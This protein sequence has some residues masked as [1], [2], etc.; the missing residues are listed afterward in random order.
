VWHNAYPL[1][2]VD[3]GEWAAAKPPDQKCVSS[4]HST[5]HSDFANMLIIV[6]H[7]LQQTVSSNKGRYASLAGLT[8]ASVLAVPKHTEQV[9]PTSLNRISVLGV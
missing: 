5:S 6:A 1:P 3:E 9:V 7:W 2:T 8:T 4:I